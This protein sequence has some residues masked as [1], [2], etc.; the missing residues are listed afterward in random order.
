MQAQRLLTQLKEEPGLRMDFLPVNPALPGLL[1]HLQRIKY[2]RTA[3]TFPYYLLTLLFRIPGCDVIH[4]FS[5]SY[6]SYLL[7]PL[8]A[9]CAGRLYGKAFL[10]NYRS[11]EAED[12]LRHSPVATATLRWADA[13]VTP[14]G[15]LVDVFA[16]F[17][18]RARSIFNSVPIERFPPVERVPLRP[19]FFSNRNFDPMYNVGNTLEAFALIQ[20]RFPEASLAVAG[21]G[22]ERGKLRGLAESLGLRNVVFH[23]AVPP[24]EMPRLYAQAHVYLNSSEIDN[25][26]NS[27]IEA[28]AA[29][30]PVVTTAAG[31]IPYIVR[32]E[33]TGLLVPCGQPQAMAAAAIRLL[34][35]QDFA[36]L[37]AA[38]ARAECERYRWDRIQPE[39]VAL[40]REMAGR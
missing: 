9:M 28:Y 6:L 33:E 10:V 29:G 39:W 2:V 18:L 40:Y 22:Q 5:A 26:P 34:E 24:A 21:D 37:L 1:G 8:P 19:V 20:R 31:G 13:I 35:E 23:G 12:H 15:F 11:G 14:S 27:I 7:A 3:L 25:M 36:A 16:K 32:H 17:G 4:I 38:N 30:T